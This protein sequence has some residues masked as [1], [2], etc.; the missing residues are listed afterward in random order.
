MDSWFTLQNIA[1]ETP[2]GDPTADINSTHLEYVL[3]FLGNAG[4]K[5]FDRWKPTGSDA[6]VA[7]KKKS[8]QEFLYYLTSMMDHAV[9]QC[10]RIYQL[11][12]VRIQPGESPDELV[13]HLQALADQCNFL[14]EEGKEQN[15]QYRFIRALNDKEL[16]KKLL[17]LDLTATTSKML[18][19]C[20][21]HIAI[22]DNLKAMGLNQ[23]KSVNVIWKQSK[24]HHG[25]KPHADSVHSC[26]HYT[27]SHAPD[28]SSCSAWEDK[29]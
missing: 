19:V 13:D 17:A 29:C 15:I 10:C 6:E 28:R 2:P 24:P 8:A 7:K 20:C 11:E 5:K 25:K 1:P 18:E 16:V 22:S 26:G 21:T 12:D 14:T 3:N 23:Q 27:K 9:L 4:H